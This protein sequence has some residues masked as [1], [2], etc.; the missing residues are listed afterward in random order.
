MLQGIVRLEGRTGQP[1]KQLSF[2]PTDGSLLCTT[3]GGEALLWRIRSVLHQQ[4]LHKTVLQL[5]PGD[6]CCQ[7]P[8]P[9]LACL[10]NARP[11]GS[12]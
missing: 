3:G 7:L 2:H 12:T 11:V 10:L 6:W 8:K 5:P 1:G 9:L 4:E